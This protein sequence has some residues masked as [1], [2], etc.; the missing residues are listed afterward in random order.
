SL[1]RSS[2]GNNETL[3]RPPFRVTLNFSEALE[4]RLTSIQVLDGK[5]KK[6]RVDTNDL[7]FEPSDPTFASIG[8]KTLDPGLYYVKWSNVSAVD[9]HEYAGQYPFIVLNNDGTFPEGV[10]LTS[11]TSSSSGGELL[12]RNID[13]A[14]KW[15]ALLSLAAVA[16]A[17]LLFL[18]R[19][20]RMRDIG[21]G[22]LVV[23]CV[24]A[25]FAN[26]MISHAAT[27]AGKFWSVS[28][29][30]L[31][32][33]ASSAWLGALVMLLLFML[34]RRRQRVAP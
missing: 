8:V 31:H 33:V 18:G 26:S 7:T 30:L 6:T 2:P 29:D 4:Q 34:S 19:T 5:E 1:I 3:R 20:A 27:G 16:G 13:S 12:P 17:A 25:M 15:I 32:L 10:T 22:V 21:I 14:L 28:S 9:G 24:G 23:A 11:G